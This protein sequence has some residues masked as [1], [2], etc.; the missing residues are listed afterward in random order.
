MVRVAN[1]SARSCANGTR[2]VLVLRLKGGEILMKN[3]KNYLPLALVAVVAASI[4]WGVSALGV[5][6][7]SQVVTPAVETAPMTSNLIPVAPQ[8]AQLTSEPAPLV[9]PIA[10]AKPAIAERPVKRTVAARPRTVNPAADEEAA[11]NE[12]GESSPEATLPVRELKK[13][14]G[15]GTKTAIAIG[16]GAATG[17]IIGGI[18]GGGKGAA[19]GAAIGGGGGAIY[20]IIRKKQGKEVW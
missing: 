18:A 7:K 5:N 9:L 6:K 14:M 3:Y 11:R 13:G 8:P 15:N 10:T 4:G 2:V 20:S 16:G 12:T 17:A 1:R 19:I